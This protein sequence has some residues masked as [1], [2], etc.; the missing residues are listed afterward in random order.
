[1]MP[2]SIREDSDGVVS[3]VHTLSD[4]RSYDVADFWFRPM[5]ERLG[6]SPETAKDWQRQHAEL[7]AS[8]Y[9]KTFAD[10]ASVKAAQRLYTAAPDLLAALKEIVTICTESAGDCRKRMGTRVGNTLVAAQEA[11]AKAEAL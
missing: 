3:V 7:L 6:T 11:I 8:A 2:F 10:P 9:N 4:G 5:V 1:M